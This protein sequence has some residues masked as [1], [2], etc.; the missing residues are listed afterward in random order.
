MTQNPKYE[1]VDE[2][3]RNFWKGF[4]GGVN[5]GIL[6]AQAEDDDFILDH[7][8]TRKSWRDFLHSQIDKAYEQGV[9]DTLGAY[10]IK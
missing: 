1:E 4:V 3:F 2:D 6:L 10:K 5:Q 8:E 9:K 7:P